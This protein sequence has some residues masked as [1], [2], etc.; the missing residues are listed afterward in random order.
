MESVCEILK[1]SPRSQKLE[2]TQING[3][4]L[5]IFYLVLTF[6]DYVTGTFALMTN[7]IKI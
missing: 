4:C 6:F 2:H 1:T 7:K 3:T 5:T